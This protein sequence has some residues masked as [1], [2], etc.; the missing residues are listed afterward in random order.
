M[1]SMC[2]DNG[3]ILF[4]AYQASEQQDKYSD[5]V[6]LGVIVN[7]MDMG[8]LPRKLHFC[9]FQRIF[10]FKTQKNLLLYE[11]SLVRE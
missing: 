11:G 4:N 6:F 1:K 2:R 10:S 8:V 3:A 7:G 9:G 5:F